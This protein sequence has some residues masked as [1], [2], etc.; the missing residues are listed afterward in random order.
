MKTTQ[1]QSPRPFPASGSAGSHEEIELVFRPIT[2]GLGFHP[3]SDGMPYAPI[4][5]KPQTGFRPPAPMGTGAVSA[6]TPSF[7]SQLP[8]LSARPIPRVSVPV[9]QPRPNPEAALNVANPLPVP[10]PEYGFVYLLKRAFAYAIDS[11]LNLALCGGALSMALL[12]QSLKPELLLNPGVILVSVLFFAFFNWAIVTAQEIAFGTSLGKRLFRLA[13]NGPTSAIFLRAFFFLPSAGF[14]GA[15]LL[16]SVL[17][18]RKRCWH[19]LIVDLQP[20]EIARL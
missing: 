8:P 13:V 5:Q 14:F 15:G 10:H 2:S 9:A 17:D 18:R 11:A 6:G 4:S 7:A 12:E 19:D 3:F 1:G 20:S 16:W